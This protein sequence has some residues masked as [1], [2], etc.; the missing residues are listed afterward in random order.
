MF[1]IEEVGDVTQKLPEY[2][3]AQCISV[4]CAMGSGVVLAFRKVFPG[5][6]ASCMNYIDMAK[7]NTSKM[8]TDGLSSQFINE[9]GMYVPYRHKD[10]SGVIYNM[11]TKERYWFKAGKGI[12]YDDYLLNLKESLQFVRDMMIQYNETKLAIPK[13]GS[14]RDKC[15]WK[16]VSSIIIEVFMGT[17]IEIVI[18]DYFE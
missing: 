5:L 15:Q 3:T 4:D 16:D 11:F 2:V 13:I 6:K 12:T 17:D 8:T 18:C 9:R 14:G 7:S 10:T 1:Y